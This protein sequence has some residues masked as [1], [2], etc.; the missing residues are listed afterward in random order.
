MNT[1]HVGQPR[2]VT[3]N[4]V[5]WLLGSREPAIR[6]LARRDLLVEATPPP[7]D[8]TDGPLVQGLLAG[9]RPDGGFGNH[10]YAKWSGSFWR[11]I[12]LVELGIPAGEPRAV[13]AARHALDW[14]CGQD[15]YHAKVNG[16]VRRHACQDGFM[17]LVATRLAMLDDPRAT[18][19]ASNLIAWQ[20]PDGGWNCDPR[21]EVR[22]SS[23]HESFAPAWALWEY[24]GAA[25]DPDAAAAARRTGELLLTRR[26]FRSI[27]TGAVI[28]P[29]WTKLHWPHYWHYDVLAGLALLARIGLVT[30]P[31]AGE[32]LDLLERRRTKGGA[33]RPGGYWWKP[34]GRRGSNVEV[35]NW[36]RGG[37][38]EMIT[39]QTLR[40]LR[41]AGR[42]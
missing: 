38:N 42:A 37:P 30:D 41:A 17:L 36:G 4:P 27:R 25:K 2:C 15:R 16:L 20:W 26:L 40:I 33:W 10:P 8:L 3:T 28:H 13:A 31:R 23:F 29:S 35:V 24:A 9:Q 6:Y 21:P 14:V 1:C 34:P 7:A 5:E 22:R 18:R 39:L 11:V 32:A 12:S 19:L